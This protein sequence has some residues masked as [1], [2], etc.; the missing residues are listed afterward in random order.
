MKKSCSI[1]I[2]KRSANTAS[3]KENTCTVKFYGNVQQCKEKTLSTY[4][5]ILA[6]TVGHGLLMEQI[7]ANDK[8]VSACM[9]YSNH[10]SC[11]FVHLFVM[12]MLIRWWR[13][14]LP[15]HGDEDLTNS[16]I[17]AHDIELS[18]ADS[19]I[20]RTFGCNRCLHPPGHLIE[21]PAYGNNNQC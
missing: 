13:K 2:Y 6:K 3:K 18:G 11:N 14:W 15:P 17:S 10:W 9:P 19:V 12:C 16:Y 8:I 21:L 20:V 1:F 5:N 4:N 7:A